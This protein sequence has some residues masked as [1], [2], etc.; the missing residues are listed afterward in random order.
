M[1]LTFTAFNVSFPDGDKIITMTF[2]HG[3]VGRRYF[4]MI[5]NGY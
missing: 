2:A 5:N 1:H 3:G 4:L